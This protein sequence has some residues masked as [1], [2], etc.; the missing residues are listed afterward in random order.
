MNGTPRAS[1]VVPVFNGAAHLS[2]AL[3][4]VLA[5]TFADFEL[6]VI[7]DGSADGTGEVISHFVR[8]DPRLVAVHQP[9]RGLPAA[10]NAGLRRARAEIVAFLDADDCWLP[11]K[12][13]CQLAYLE[14]HPDCL[15]CFTYVEEMD[16][17][18]R[19]LTPWSA[20]ADQYGHPIVTPD[21]L[22]E[23]GNLIAGSASGVAARTAAVREAGGFDE[24]LVACEDLDLWYRLSLRAPLRPVPRV[25][26]RIRR[27]PGQMQSDYSRVLVGRIQFLE[28][29]RRRGDSRH[30]QVARKVEKRLRAHLLRRL[31]RRGRLLRSGRLVLALLTRRRAEE[32]V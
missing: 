3:E 25:L 14:Q 11:R 7:D 29:V 32:P 5:Q 19:L 31:L 22:V 15:A 16:D 4:S 20:F 13:E 17:A 10:R 21:L 26:V 28:K 2:D 1:V 27:R 6:I 30:A 18:L 24:R 23:R 12:L 8:R 9:N